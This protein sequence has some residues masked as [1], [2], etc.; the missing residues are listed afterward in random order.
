MT[1]AIRR[2]D[3]PSRRTARI[4]ARSGR[5]LGR[6]PAAQRGPGAGPGLE[7]QPGPR[8]TT[9]PCGSAWPTTSRPGRWPPAWS[10]SGMAWYQ[11]I[12]TIMVAQ[13]H[14]ARPDAAEQPC[15]HEVRDPVPGLRAGLVRRLRRQPPGPDPGRRRL[16]LVRHPDLDRRRRDLHGRWAPSWATAG[17]RRPRS[18][19]ASARPLTAVDAVAQL[20]RLLGTQHRDHLARHGRRPPVRELG[21]SVRPDRRGRSCSSG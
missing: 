10:R 11:A 15:R 18:R 9:W 21:R 17:R 19:S 5:G 16:R 8:T 7:A 2:G 6:F 14:R 1:T 13:R 4:D 3:R 20:R 12:F